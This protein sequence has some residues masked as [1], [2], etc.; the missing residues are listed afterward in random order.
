MEEGWYTDMSKNAQDEDEDSDS[1]GEK[2]RSKE[3]KDKEEGRKKGK[4]VCYGG[5]PELSPHGHLPLRSCR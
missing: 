2:T 3:K 4:A 5:S 1:G